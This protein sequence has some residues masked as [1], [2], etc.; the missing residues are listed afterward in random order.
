MSLLTFE[1][2]RFK[3][4]MSYG[5]SWTEIDLNSS[6]RTL[7]IG[8][9][10]NGKSV[11][12]TETLCFALFGKSFRGAN[13]PQLVNSINERDC[14]VEVEFTKR[15]SRYK[16]VRGIKPAIFEIYKDGNLIPVDSSLKD[17]QKEFESTVI[18]TNFDTFIQVVILGSASYIPFMKLAAKERRQIVETLLDLRV[19][20]NIHATMKTKLSE[21]RSVL[22]QAELRRDTIQDKVAD[23]TAILDEQ[24]K[25]GK[26]T[27][28]AILKKIS[29]L[30]TK[31]ADMERVIQDTQQ[32]INSTALDS[33]ERSQ[34]E[35]ERSRSKYH[36][37]VVE[38]SSKA[39]QL[40]KRLRFF[41]SNT[42]CPTCN[43][44]IDEEYSSGIQDNLEKSLES[45]ENTRDR[46]EVSIQNLDGE[47]VEFSKQAK[48][49]KDSLDI[50]N[51][52]GRAKD[53]ESRA[54]RDQ[55]DILATLSDV[56][57]QDVS[58]IQ[59]KITQC[60]KELKTIESDVATAEELLS[61]YDQLASLFSDKGIKTKI[62]RSYL[63]FINKKINEFLHDMEFFVL[64]EFDEGFNET[65]LARHRD[66]FKFD[67]FSEG[68]RARINLALLLT[69]RE[70]AQR[71]NTLSTN[72]LVFDEIFDSSLDSIG[73]EELMRIL[74][75]FSDT[76]IFVISH[77]VEMQE[78]FDRV[79]KAVKSSDFSTLES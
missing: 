20:S 57:S 48:K 44:D 13:K 68:E 1:R 46:I 70:I 32:K 31:I 67:S 28:D 50:V 15:N 59:D 39:K 35:L 10:G 23:F 22:S 26:Q 30:E 37:L 24:T 51:K 34:K 55:R 47:S 64:F 63:P 43:Q 8:K 25:R 73:S 77:R 71:K 14:V 6:P 18:E 62:V 49:I 29:D 56:T 4:F 12:I 36:S 42:V 54:L 45:I 27:K 16:V 38:A 72:L 78:H 33:I 74:K 2:I 66:Q 19:F 65:I 60:E 7:V 9:N 58:N 41:E 11:A 69:W 40:K 21:T 61:D 75:S 52:L 53:K 3:N 79:I 17:Q 5:N 76:N